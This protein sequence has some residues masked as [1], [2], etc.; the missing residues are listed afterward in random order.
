MFLCTFNNQ[1]HVIRNKPELRIQEYKKTI[2]LQM[3]LFAFSV[4]NSK[5]FNPMWRGC[6]GPNGGDEIWG[7][8]F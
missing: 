1:H 5:C 4:E 8:S 3:A 7:F 6:E 2:F